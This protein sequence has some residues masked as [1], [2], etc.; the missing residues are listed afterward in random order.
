MAIFGRKIP[1][2]HLV[3][4][5]KDNATSK[6]WIVLLEASTIV[7]PS[8][9]RLRI[10]RTTQERKIVRRRVGLFGKKYFLVVDGYDPR[11][12]A[13]YFCPQLYSY[14]TEKQLVPL[15]GEA[16]GRMIARALESGI[17]DRRPWY[18]PSEELPDAPIVATSMGAEFDTLVVE[19]VESPPLALAAQR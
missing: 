9:D 19:T 2:H 3:Q 18:E 10:A 1:K 14:N 15:E 6:D 16:I 13:V 17:K 5:H 8:P 11:I 4:I 7:G 12:H